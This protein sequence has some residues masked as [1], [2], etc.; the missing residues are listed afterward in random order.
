M[1]D[2]LRCDGCNKTADKDLSSPSV[3][4]Q[5]M[6]G[7]PAAKGWV[8]FDRADLCATCVAKV[9]DFIEGLHAEPVGNSGSTPDDATAGPPN[10]GATVPLRSVSGEEGRR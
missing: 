5:I 6:L 4:I 10:R 8:R 9:R 7:Q 1:S 3:T 2:F